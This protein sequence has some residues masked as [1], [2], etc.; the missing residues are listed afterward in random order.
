MVENGVLYVSSPD[1][2]VRAIDVRTGHEIW[3]SP[4]HGSV[5]NNSSG[6][7]GVVG[8]TPALE[9][10]VLYVGSLDASV[11]AIDDKT[12]QEILTFPTKN[13]VLRT[14]TVVDGVVYVSSEDYQVYAINASTGREIWS[15]FIGSSVYSLTVADGIVYISTP[16]GNIY[17]LTIPASLS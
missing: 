8:S 4:A 10:G 9:R 5:P 1:K 15:F 2:N 13:A 11:H 7:G 16:Q 12:G 14:P 3:T 6:L 17:A